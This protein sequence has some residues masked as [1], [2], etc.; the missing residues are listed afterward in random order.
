MKGNSRSTRMNTYFAYL[1][2]KFT[3]ETATANNL[4]L[5][6]TTITTWPYLNHTPSDSPVR[7]VRDVDRLTA[8]VDFNGSNL[9]SVCPRRHTKLRGSDT[10]SNNRRKVSRQK[11]G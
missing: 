7:S 4:R 1:R 2:S 8:Q 9:D 10:S 6:T 11:I 3:T 5:V